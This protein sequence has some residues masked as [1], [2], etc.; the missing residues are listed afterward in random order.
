MIE[1]Q[2]RTNAIHNCTA[3]YK[4]KPLCKNCKTTVNCCLAKQQC[5]GCAHMGICLPTCETTAN[6]MEQATN[7][8]KNPNRYVTITTKIHAAL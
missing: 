8:C 4:A 1:L 5:N 7:L 2:E 3:F 6:W